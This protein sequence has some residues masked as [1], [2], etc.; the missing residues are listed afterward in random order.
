MGRLSPLLSRSYQ[1]L[2]DLAHKFI[3]VSVERLPFVVMFLMIHS[4]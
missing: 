4:S 1:S 3:D 2:M